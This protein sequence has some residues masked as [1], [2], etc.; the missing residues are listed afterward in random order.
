MKKSI[1]KNLLTNK[2]YKTKYIGYARAIDGDTDYLNDQIKRLTDFGCQI[3]FSELLSCHQDEKPQFEK[4]ISSLAKNDVFILEKLDIAFNSQEQFISIVFNLLNEGIKFRTLSGFVCSEKDI[5]VYHS[6]FNV[7]NE[8]NKLEE[9]LIT[10]KKKESSRNKRLVGVNLGGRPKISALKESLVLRL[11][12]EGS[13]YRTIRLQTGIALSTI[14]RI[15]L[16]AE[17]KK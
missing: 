3:V 7:L 4:A 6:I 2:K 14:R 12:N 5:G 13:S 1:G 10:K 15:I 16:D 11:R 8:L 17:V 9:D